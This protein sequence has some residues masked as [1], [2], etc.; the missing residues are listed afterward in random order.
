MVLV[1]IVVTGYMVSEIKT[2]SEEVSR[3]KVG[4][5]FNGP[6]TSINL[7]TVK[8]RTPYE[9]GGTIGFRSG[10]SDTP[11]EDVRWDRL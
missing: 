4:R 3:E 10:A 9:R 2:K 5:A 1:G 7:K 8:R 11:S 6:K